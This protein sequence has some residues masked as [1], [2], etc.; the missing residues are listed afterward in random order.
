MRFVRR[1]QEGLERCQN[2]L[3]PETTEK[4]TPSQSW[5]FA[6]ILLAPTDERLNHDPVM[7]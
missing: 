6:V 4:V 3:L 5:G 1:A 7:R 2:L